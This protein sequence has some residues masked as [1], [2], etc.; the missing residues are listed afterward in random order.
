MRKTFIAAVGLALALS[1]LATASAAP[2]SHQKLNVPTAG[3]AKCADPSVPGGEWPS[4]EQNLFNTRAQDAEKKIDAS[5]VGSLTAK[6][7]FSAMHEG[8]TGSFE[9]TP[10]VAEGCVS[11]TTG[12]GYIY[13]INADTGALVW[14]GR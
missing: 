6:W 10:V 12:S 3:K 1:L 5:N 11:M 14:K 9:T 13:A 2:S 4:Y 8:G 7:T